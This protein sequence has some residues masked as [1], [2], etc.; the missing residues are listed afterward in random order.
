MYLKKKCIWGCDLGSEHEKY[1]TDI[2]IKG[3]LIITDYPQKIKSFY[4]KANQDCLEEMETC[5]AMDL[6]VPNIGELIG[7]SMREDNFDHIK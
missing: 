7:G 1:M 4:M 5:Q 2:V 6:L 3:P